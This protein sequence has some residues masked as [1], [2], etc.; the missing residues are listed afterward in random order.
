MCLEPLNDGKNRCLCCFFGLVVTSA[1]SLLWCVK[2]VMVVGI[3]RYIISIVKN[4]KTKKKKVQ[5][6]SRRV[7]SRALAIAST[8]LVLCCCCNC[9]W[10]HSSSSFSSSSPRRS[11]WKRRLSRS[12]VTGMKIW[13]PKRQFIPSFGPFQA[14]CCRN[15]LKLLSKASKN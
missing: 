1:P 10:W 12:H 15:T 6:G 4:N 11:Q 8:A 5:R 9:R 7:M 14:F 3:T 13:R 2:V